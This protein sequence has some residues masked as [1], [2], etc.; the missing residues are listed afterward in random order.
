[1]L[2]RLGL[3]DAEELFSDIPAAL[4]NPS[5]ALPEGLAEPDLMRHL[6]ALAAAN[7]AHELVCFLGAGAYDHYIP[8][9]VDE[10]A[11]RA[12]FYTGYTPYQPEMT[13]GILQAIYEY[14]TIM[15]ELTGLDA[16]NASLYDAAT[17]VWEALILS[18]REAGRGRFVLSSGVSPRIVAALRT[19]AAAAGL[20]I[21]VL[22]DD[23]AGRL[24]LAAAERAL[25][26]G[27]S[28]L[29]AAL[30]SAYGVVQDLSTAAELAHAHGALL[31]VA[32]NP[33]ALAI[34]KSPGEM[35]ADVCVGSG[36]PLGV[37]L[38]F[39]GPYFGFMAVRQALVR[40]MPGRIVGAT[41]DTE[42][43]RGFVL[44]LQARE[45]HIRRERATSNVCTNQA[46]MA[47]R[48]TIYCTLVGQ[49]GLIE[50]AQSCVRRA[51]QLR[52]ALL[53]IAGIEPLHPGPHFHEF[54][55]RLPARRAR[56]VHAGA[57]R[58]G[59]LAGLPLGDWDP[60]LED[61]L[62]L[63]ATEQR[64]SEEIDG[65]AAVVAELIEA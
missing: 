2:A 49:Q 45:Q 54:A 24:D 12:E 23:A 3:T 31:I 30:P 22:P 19:Y 51:A 37:P 48:A 44:T 20:A 11:G 34:L 35:G 13:Q 9:A 52:A 27:A 59:W 6:R 41:V 47:L 61:C 60:D 17:A 50:V 38:Q 36:Q 14:Q 18:E 53:A 29:V 33:L 8:A 5:L 21:E 42:G 39:G 15:C 65:L 16:S 28:A 57:Q 25:A 62:L 40:K 56:A 10:L 55:I 7:P 26:G 58:R 46:L 64:T 32:A 1:M 43:Q 63:C 4:R